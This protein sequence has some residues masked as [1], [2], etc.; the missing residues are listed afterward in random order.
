MVRPDDDIA[1][2]VGALVAIAPWG[3][4]PSERAWTAEGLARVRAP[5]LVVDGSADDIVDFQQGVRWAFDR[6]SGTERSL[7]VFRGARH[8]VGVNAPQPAAADDPTQMDYFGDPVWRTDRLNGISVHFITAFLDA[9][10][11]GEADKAK[12]FHVPTPNAEDGVWPQAFGELKGP[13]FA[14]DGQPGYWRGFQRRSAVGLEL[15]TL[16]PGAT[17][18]GR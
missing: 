14:G 5:T 4:Q 2:S 10:L 1:R 7:L 16:P 13:Q 18:E 11:K 12:Y 9:A 3:A 15:H 6:L 17:A 8:G